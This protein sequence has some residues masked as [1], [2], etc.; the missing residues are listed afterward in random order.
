MPYFES[1]QCRCPRVRRS[2]NLLQRIPNPLLHLLHLLL[3]LFCR[4]HGLSGNNAQQR[5]IIGSSFFFFFSCFFFFCC[6]CFCCF[7]FCF[8]LLGSVTLRSSGDSCATLISQPHSIHTR[9]HALTR[10]H[11]QIVQTCKIF[12]LCASQTLDCQP[13]AGQ[14]VVRHLSVIGFPFMLPFV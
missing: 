5:P 6:F 4:S 8:L 1:Q 12:N 7:F 2:S 3:L 11:T 10:M 9:T 13:I 14:S